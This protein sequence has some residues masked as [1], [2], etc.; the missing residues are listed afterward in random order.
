MQIK[1]HFQFSKQQRNGIFLLLILI[2]TL[3]C[4]YFFY[5][6]NSVNANVENE[7]ELK[8]RELAFFLREVDSLKQVAVENRKPKTYPFN[9]NFITDYKGYNLGMSNEEIDR[10]HHFR[11][12]NKWI[13]S[14]KEFQR[15]TKVSDSLLVVLSPNFK[16]PKWISNKSNKRSYS[17]SKEPKSFESKI[18]LN[19]A[20][21]VQLKAVKG[22]GDKLSQR[23]IDYRDE[24]KGF[25]SDIELSEIYGLSKDV[26]AELRKAFVLKTP[27]TINKVILN[28]ATR[29]E[30]VKIKYIDY[31]IAYNILEERTLRGSYNSV[32]E[33]KKVKDFPINKF[34]II[35]LYLQ[36]N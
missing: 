30:L 17:K 32:N 16:F 8:K 23:I 34:E 7:L 11:A 2:V 33:L 3:Q 13:N 31:E 4:V 26:I 12:Q 35:R 9:P 20:T 28:E 22:I 18:D 5:E 6:S 29:D 25:I 19:K 1:S 14:A 10:L 15:V 27:R 24:Q 21:A 36:L